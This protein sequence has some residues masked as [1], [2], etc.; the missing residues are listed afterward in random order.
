MAETI[1]VTHHRDFGLILD[2]SNESGSSSG[3]HQIDVPILGEE[4]GDLI[5]SGNGLNEGGREG[6]LSESLLDEGGKDGGGVSGFS[7]GFED[8]GVS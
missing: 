3:H 7:S 4:S 1:S 8:S 5:S 2:G 6:S